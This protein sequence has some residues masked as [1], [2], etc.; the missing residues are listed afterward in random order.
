M[1]N[2]RGAAD[3]APTL[4]GYGSGLSSNRTGRSARLQR[5]LARADERALGKLRW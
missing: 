2:A 1:K 4:H 3:L 5:T